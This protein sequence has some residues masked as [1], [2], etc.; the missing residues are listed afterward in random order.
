MSDQQSMNQQMGREARYSQ[1]IGNTT[2]KVMIRFSNTSQE[3]VAMRSSA[4]FWVIA[5]KILKNTLRKCFKKDV[6]LNTEQQRY[7]IG[8]YVRELLESQMERILFV[9]DSRRPMIIT[10]NL[11][12]GELKNSPDL[13]HVYIYDP[14]GNGAFRSSLT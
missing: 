3:M 6:F 1:K 5:E 9:I 11:K 13:D 2:Y 4:L 12:L 14:S 7:V 8:D 10:S